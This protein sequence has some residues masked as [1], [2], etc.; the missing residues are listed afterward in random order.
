MFW[1]DMSCKDNTRQ[2][3]NRPPSPNTHYSR[4]PHIKKKGWLFISG[5]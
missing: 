3:I 5:F 1:G 2:V 4:D